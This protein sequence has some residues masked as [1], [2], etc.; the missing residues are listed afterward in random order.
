MA[1]YSPPTLFAPTSPAPVSYPTFAEFFAGIGLGRMG[2]ERWGWSLALAN[3]IDESK[4]TMYDGHFGD[5]S[6]HYDTTDIHRLDPAS[7]PN[8][9][10]ATASFPCTDLSLA[11]GRKGLCGSQSSAFWGFYRVM[12]G[13]GERR[14]PLVLL[15]NVTAFL[16]SHSGRDFHDAMLAMNR[17]GYSV[18]PFVLDA[19]WFVPQSRP[20]LFIVAVAPDNGAT[21]P[22]SGA[23]RGAAAP[24][25]GA[26][27]NIHADSGSRIRPRAVMEFIRAHPEIDWRL[28]DLP[29]PPKGS[30][31]TLPDVL[32]D[33][34]DDA[35]E[36]WSHDRAKYLYGQMSPRHRQIADAMIEKPQ[37]SFGTVFRRVRKQPGG[38]KRSMAELR[39]DGIAGCLRMPTGGSG[40]QILFRAGYGS[41]SAR[42]LTPHE[43][44]RL[45][46]ADGYRVTVSLNRALAGFGDAVCVPAI[47]WIA[48]HY[49]NP[50]LA[51]EPEPPKV[52]S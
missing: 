28:Y 48:E 31:E 30:E 52:T 29:E 23:E 21:A 13:M 44:A 39:T 19:R 20:R 14:P 45:M 1:T 24:N 8:V 2:L 33:L 35:P 27:A 42:L 26:R 34:D 41:F 16:T 40:R 43:C 3:D 50:L 17:L 12:E 18:D 46:G 22:I 6:I 5:A 32:D 36:W 11:G 38:G 47:S 9:E 15:E 10:L 4:R 7:V 49:L 37:W 25:G 51:L